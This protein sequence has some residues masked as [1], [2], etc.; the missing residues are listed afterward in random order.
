MYTVLLSRYPYH[1]QVK[2]IAGFLK[3]VIAVLGRPSGILKDGGTD[4]SKAVR[5]LAQEGQI[6]HEIDDISHVIANL[7]K[8]EYAHHPMFKTF[9]SSCGKASQRLK[10]TMLAF[11]APPKVSTKARFMNIHRLVEWADKVLKHSPVGRVAKGS[12]TEKLRVC[13]DQL[14]QCKGLIKRLL[15]DATALLDCQMLLKS[16]GLSSKTSQQCKAL[17]APIP[18]NSTI[19]IGFIYWLE[20][21]LNIQMSRIYVN[22]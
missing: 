5:L 7:L 13:V 20:S 1:G 15:R 3:K 6:C 21:Q 9:V 12:M 19:R 2:K 17:I 11:L 14:P 10:Q 22:L 4:L 16:K 18:Y 8:H